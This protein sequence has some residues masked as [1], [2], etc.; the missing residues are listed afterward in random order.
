MKKDKKYLFVGFLAVLM[1]AFLTGSV[2]SADSVTIVG[3]LKCRWSNRDR[4]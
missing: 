3:T 1:I 2:M 4:Q